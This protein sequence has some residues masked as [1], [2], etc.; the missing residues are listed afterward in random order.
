MNV[1]TN[2]KREMRRI[3]KKKYDDDEKENEIEKLRKEKE[4]LK[5]AKS[6]RRIKVEQQLKA[7]QNE[8]EEMKKQIEEIK[9]KAGEEKQESVV[10]WKWKENDGTWI[11][12]DN[13]ISNI[14]EKLKT[15]ESHQYTFSG[16]QQTY[17]ITKLSSTTAE[18]KNTKTNVKRDVKRTK[19]ERGLNNIKYPEWWNMN[20]VNLDKELSGID[21]KYAV[22]KL[23]ELNQN[24]MPAEEIIVNFKKT[25]PSKTVLKVFSIENQ[26]LYDSY[27]NARRKLIELIGKE[28]LNERDVF[29]GSRQANVM[30]MIQKEGF[31]KEFN[32]SAASGKGTYFARDA[33]YSVNGGYCCQKDGVYQI[34]QC[35]VMMG[36]S[37]QGSSSYELT[38]WPKKDGGKGL[39]YDSLV[40]RMKD[41]TVF[42]IHEN[43]RAYPM[44]VIHF[45]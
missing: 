26:M 40:N 22:P 31:R 28:K 44:F 37:H 19:K 27:W 29:H 13:A 42:V 45:K 33:S 34:F 9:Q 25:C 41:P 39:I 32:K 10:I 7:K 23:V 20:D 5:R 43:V 6:D 18:Q 24:T 8:L 38:N 12:Y 3:T 35:R 30:G 1:G 15:K 2:V 17:K 11:S 14:I 4:L 21:P 36:E 16:N